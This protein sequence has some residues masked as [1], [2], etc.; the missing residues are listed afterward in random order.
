MCSA[1]NIAAKLEAAGELS[2]AMEA[3]SMENEK[4]VDLPI[5]CS[6][7]A[8]CKGTEQKSKLSVEVLI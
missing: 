3:M 4:T 6:K 5:D 7:L 1:D 8:K 2:I